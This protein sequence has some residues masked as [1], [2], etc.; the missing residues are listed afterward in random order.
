MQFSLYIDQLIARIDLQKE[1]YSKGER[2]PA[3]LFT[4]YAAQRAE[5]EAA[6]ETYGAVILPD[7]LAAA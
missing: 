3:K 1:A 2:I 7:Q 5:L 4:I 6:K